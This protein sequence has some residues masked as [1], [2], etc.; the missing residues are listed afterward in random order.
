MDE[1]KRLGLRDRITTGFMFTMIMKTICS[2][3]SKSSG[4]IEKFVV[5]MSKPEI[6]R[7]TLKNEMIKA[8]GE[9]TSAQINLESLSDLLLITS[10]NSLKVGYKRQYNTARSSFIQK[11]S[12][13]AQSSFVQKGE[14]S[15]RYKMEKHCGVRRPNQFKA[16][17]LFAKQVSFR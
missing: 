8:L 16:S 10:E 17:S 6:Y 14:I 15:S 11:Q 5:R 1:I 3:I 2:E 12:H 4:K 7:E 13:Q 9:M